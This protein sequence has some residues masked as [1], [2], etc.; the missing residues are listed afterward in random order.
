MSSSDPFGSKQ[1]TWQVNQDILMLENG[2]FILL[3]MNRVPVPDLLVH[4][5]TE[6]LF[7]ISK[8]KQYCLMRGKER[9][10]SNIWPK[11]DTASG[12]S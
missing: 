1:V 2:Y 4:I 7:F 9:L 11:K 8:L 12:V 5:T 3:S 6:F 10:S